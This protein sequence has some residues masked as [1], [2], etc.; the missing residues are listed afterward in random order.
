MLSL[1]RPERQCKMP[2]ARAVQGWLWQ[3][4][5]KPKL[6]AS[7][8]AQWLR[9]CLPMQGTQAWA[10]VWEDPTC[11]RATR[12]VS[13]NYW[14]CASGACAPNKRGRDS[15]RPAHCDEEWPPLAATRESS[16]TET[17]TQHSQKKTKKQKTKKNLNWKD[18]REDIPFFSAHSC[19]FYVVPGI[20]VAI[21]QH[22]KGGCVQKQ[23]QRRD[24]G[25]TKVLKDVSEGVTT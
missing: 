9:V 6:R 25:S 20:P 1:R 13:H 16:H 22:R 5:L 17:K 8:V 11:C 10:L 2:R 23:R 19:L 7:P 14:A 12:P 4:S 15:E 18:A 3:E 24:T 21:T